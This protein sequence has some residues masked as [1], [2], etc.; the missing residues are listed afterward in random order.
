MVVVVVSI[1]LP[2]WQLII[3]DNLL[4]VN[5]SPVNT[6]FGLLG[7]PF[8]VPIMLAVNIASILAFLASGIV[9]IIYAVLPTKPYS[10]DLLGFAWRKPIY[11][12]VILVAGLLVITYSAQSFLGV[13]IPLAGT[14]KIFIPS[15]IMQGFNASI[16]ILVSTAFVWPFWVAVVAAAL[17]LA[18]RIYHRKLNPKP[19]PA[20]AGD[21]SAQPTQETPP[22]PPPPPPAPPIPMT[23]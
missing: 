2:W 15:S 17:C 23:A 8:T 10:K 11:A 14:S 13:G 22:P 5:V 7:E 12:V 9:M 21:T 3:G 19:K 6:N 1:Y 4:T 16:G 20:L 18:A